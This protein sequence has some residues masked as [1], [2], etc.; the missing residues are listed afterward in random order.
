MKTC[1][2]FS[3]GVLI[4]CICFLT[5]TACNN[6]SGGSS[7]GFPPPNS[8]ISLVAQRG[9]ESPDGNGAFLDFLFLTGINDLGQIAFRATLRKTGEH[10]PRV[11]LYL[12]DSTGLLQLA[13]VGDPVPGGN[14]TFRGF[15]RIGSLNQSGQLGFIADIENSSGG[16][17]DNE[18]LYSADSSGITELARRGDP[19][20]NGNGTFSRFCI[21]GLLDCAYIL[22]GPNDSGQVAF[23]ALLSG[24][25]GG[26]SD[27]RGI[28]LADESGIAELLRKGDP[29]PDGN[30]T[31]SD[32]FSLMGTNN[33][34]QVAFF[35]VLAGTRGGEGDNE[36]L[37]L[38][39]GSGIVQLAREGEP[40]PDG[41][42]TF[43]EFFT[44][45]APN[46]SGQVVFNAELANTSEGESDIEGVFLTGV[47]GVVELARSGDPAPDGNG[48]FNRFLF[49]R[50]PNS[51]GQVAI[52]IS[53]V[54]TS[55]GLID[56]SGIYLADING[57]QKLVRGGDPGPG[58][59]GIF[60]GF[61]GFGLL[62][63]NE[64][65]Q[66]AFLSAIGIRENNTQ[67]RGVFL[68][69]SNGL[70]NL[71]LQRQQA[72]PDGTKTFTNFTDLVGPNNNGLVA[73][74]ATLFAGV[75]P[76]DPGIFFA[77]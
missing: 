58:G 48:I 47:F 77:E 9:D 5:A 28:F 2:R 59:I 18:G 70:V 64:G 37:Y 49:P 31:F 12:T 41:N 38:I 34:G 53:L 13:R 46:Q 55:D 72:P 1:L 60:L 43:S 3:C 22:T 35:G 32:F 29:A 51:S 42:G 4:T 14:G 74:A 63:L 66:V 57:I 10:F 54:G 30:G 75:T 26:P 20:P 68:V 17:S 73:F 69:D 8:N 25:A 27:D 76:G 7:N 23:V 11:V 44:I 39:D 24:T 71:A 19:A 6:D 65:G 61:V 67:S 62:G 40:V 56:I 45:T 36:G 50:G 33:S 52:S 21:P 15:P 16:S